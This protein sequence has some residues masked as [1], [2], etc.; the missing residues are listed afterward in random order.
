MG[1]NKL[2]DCD[3]PRVGWRVKCRNS[4]Y[5]EALNPKP[6]A[7]KP[8]LATLYVDPTPTPF[9]WLQTLQ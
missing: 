5:T 1:G 8:K 7:P 2:S 9:L 6:V 4:Q 3:F